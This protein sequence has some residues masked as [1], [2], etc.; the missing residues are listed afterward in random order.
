MTSEKMQLSWQLLWSLMGL[1]GS[2]LL[3]TGICR[4]SLP[5][6]TSASTV[7]SPLPW[8]VGSLQGSPACTLVGFA[9]LWL[10]SATEAAPG[11]EVRL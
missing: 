9:P 5:M 2:S 8:A 10:F 7:L 3:L 6:L 11:P 4:D 1:T